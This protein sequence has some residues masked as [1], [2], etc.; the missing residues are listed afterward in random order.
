MV[1]FKLQN[2]DPGIKTLTIIYSVQNVF[3]T[4]MYEQFCKSFSFPFWRKFGR[5]ENYF[6]M[7]ALAVS[8]QT[9]LLHST[10]KLHF[11]MMMMI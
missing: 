6:C 8:L 9:T 5:N 2:S 4:V 10:V 11:Y 7:S 1:K 3:V